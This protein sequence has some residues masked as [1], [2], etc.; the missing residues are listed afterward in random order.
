MIRDLVRE[1][2]AAGFRP[3][4]VHSALTNTGA[5]G[6]VMSSNYNLRE[7]AIEVVI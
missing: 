2:Q 4:V 5:Y 6:R 7:P 3:V 1:R